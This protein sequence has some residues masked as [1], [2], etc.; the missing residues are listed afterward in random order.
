MTFFLHI[1]ITGPISDKD[2]R[3]I[4]RQLNRAELKYLYQE[5][6][7]RESEIEH[8]ERI[9]DTRDI[10]LMA[11]S[12]L[13]MWRQINGRHASRQAVLEALTECR[14]IRAKEVLEE[15]WGVAANGMFLAIIT[16]TEI[17]LNIDKY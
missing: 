9:A 12:V 1:V 13:R 5:L 3:D 15:K 6:N 17:T 16:D 10:D 2:I 7:L 8:A 14:Y 11:T 4:A